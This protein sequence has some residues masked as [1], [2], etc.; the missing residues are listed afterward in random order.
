MSKESEIAAMKYLAKVKPGKYWLKPG[1]WAVEL[2]ERSS[3]KWIL[4]H[5]VTSQSKDK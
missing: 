1:L 4:F 3:S 2:F 5:W